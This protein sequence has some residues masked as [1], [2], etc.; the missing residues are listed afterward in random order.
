[1]ILGEAGINI[2]GMQVGRIKTGEEAI[3]VLNVDSPV[4]SQLL[5]KIEKVDGI[6]DAKLVT[7]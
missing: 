2:A 7:L 4:S 1:M 6:L 3:M 5:R